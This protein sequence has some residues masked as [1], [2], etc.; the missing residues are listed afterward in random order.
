MMVSRMNHR[1]SPSNDVVAHRFENTNPTV[2]NIDAGV[3]RIEIK[4]A[5]PKTRGKAHKRKA[6]EQ[7]KCI[8]PWIHRSWH[9]KTLTISIHCAKF[10]V[11]LKPVFCYVL[12]YFI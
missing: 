1:K 6:C 8:K 4:K 5:H 12:M 2:G 7:V 11:C 3:Y 9:G 10:M